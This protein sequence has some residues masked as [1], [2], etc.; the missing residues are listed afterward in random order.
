MTRQQVPVTVV[1]VS[2]VQPVTTSVLLV[3]TETVVP[4]NASASQLGQ[5]LVTTLMDHVIA[6]LSGWET[7]VT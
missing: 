6:S 7:Y 5:G 3:S 1:L 4:Q 2:L